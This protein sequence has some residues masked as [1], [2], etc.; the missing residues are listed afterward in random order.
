MEEKLDLILSELGIIKS[1]QSVMKDEVNGINKRL[2]R[3]EGLI[4]QLIN[5]VKS[6][7]EKLAIVKED[8]TV[9]KQ[10]MASLK[11]AVSQSRENISRQ[12]RILES[13]AMRSLEQE[14][15]IREMK[16]AAM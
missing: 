4:M 13:L 10:D 6:T 1:G 8:V 9:I 16:R 12:D 15:R 5:I 14:T 11:E 2:D 3:H 7:N